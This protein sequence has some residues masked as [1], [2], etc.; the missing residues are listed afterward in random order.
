MNL[1]VITFDDRKASS[2]EW[3]ITYGIHSTPF[4]DVLV[5]TTLYGI[6]NLHF[7]DEP[8]E[9]AIE[10]NLYKAWNSIE[11]QC[12]PIITQP[13]C[14][15]LFQPGAQPG[16]IEANRFGNPLEP[17]SIVLKGTTFQIHV[18]KALLKIPFG[19]VITYQ[20]LAQWIDR[21]TATRAVGT[22]VGKNPI[23]YLIPCH[24]VIRVSGALGGYRWGLD[25]KASILE[26]EANQLS[27]PSDYAQ[28]TLREA[29]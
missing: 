18:W 29:K 7:L 5:A 8:E 21:P 15:R 23:A 17:L 1:N 6:C 26:W 14:D 11:I 4:G 19:K 24:R 25:R 9:L 20:E 10:N 3:L 27:P 22:A 16:N 13:L 28:E 12:D 2:T